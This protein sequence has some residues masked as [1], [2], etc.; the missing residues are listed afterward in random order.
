LEVVADVVVQ[1]LAQSGRSVKQC[2]VPI[3]GAGEAVRKAERA[4]W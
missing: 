2:V 4:L 3:P 1:M